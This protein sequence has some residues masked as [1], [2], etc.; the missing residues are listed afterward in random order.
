MDAMCLSLDEFIRKKSMKDQFALLNHRKRVRDIE[1]EDLDVDLEEYIK[2]SR[3]EEIEKMELDQGDDTTVCGKF[4]RPSMKDEG[5]SSDDESDDIKLASLNSTFVIKKE[6]LDNDLDMMSFRF[7]TPETR[8]GIRV[9]SQQFRL[10]PENIVDRPKGMKRLLPMPLD[11]S[12]RYK[13]NRFPNG[14]VHKR[15]DSRATSKTSIVSH[16]KATSSS[17]SFI[18]KGKFSYKVGEQGVLGIDRVRRLD[19]PE[20]PQPSVV[21][22]STSGNGVTVNMNWNG[23][24]EGLNKLQGRETLADKLSRAEKLVS[25]EPAPAA[26]DD[27]TTESEALSLAAVRLLQTLKA[28]NYFGKRLD[29]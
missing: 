20:A 4:D 9:R 26:P 27:E 23:F 21:Q 24:F 29:V 10:L 3:I 1:K 17:G 14:R 18:E 8:Q 6:D 5:D 11:E 7:T 12:E 22:A 15:Y 25:Q 2:E 13:K 28:K 19:R 16:L